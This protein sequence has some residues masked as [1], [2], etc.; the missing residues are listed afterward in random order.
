MRELTYTPISSSQDFETMVRNIDNN[1]KILSDSYIIRGL[2][3]ISLTP[4]IEKFVRKENNNYII[5]PNG[6][7]IVL[8][9]LGLDEDIDTSEEN[10]D[11]FISSL[12]SSNAKYVQEALE[13]YADEDSYNKIVWAGYK[14]KLDEWV[15]IILYTP[16]YFIYNYETEQIPAGGSFNSTIYFNIDTEFN[17]SYDTVS[18]ESFNE[19][20]EWVI[21]NNIPDIYYNEDGGEWRWRIN[22]V[23]TDF[24]L[25]GKPG[26]QGESG[27]IL[28]LYTTN[29]LEPSIITSAISPIGQHKSLFEIVNNGITLKGYAVENTNTDPIAV[30]KTLNITDTQKPLEESDLYTYLQDML[31]IIK[32]SVY[33]GTTFMINSQDIY[34][35]IFIITTPPDGEFGSTAERWYKYDM[36]CVGFM[37]SNQTPAL[38]LPLSIKSG[39]EDKITITQGIE[40][41]NISLKDN[42]IIDIDGKDII[43]QSSSSDI[44]ISN[45]SI[46]IEGKDISTDSVIVVK[47]NDP[48]TSST[49]TLDDDHIILS[50]SGDSNSDYV[51]ITNDDISIK[52]GSV[53]ITSVVDKLTSLSSGQVPIGG[54]ISSF[55]DL[56]DDNYIALDGSVSSLSRDAYSGF[57]TAMGITGDSWTVPDLSGRVL[58]GVQPTGTY[59]NNKSTVRSCGA[60]EDDSSTNENTYINIDEEELGKYGPIQQVN[61]CD[62]GNNR[63]NANDYWRLV[64]SQLPLHSHNTNHTHFFP[65]LDYYASTYELGQS[66]NFLSNNPILT[67]GVGAQKKFNASQVLAGFGLF[68]GSSDIASYASNANADAKYRNIF[69]E[70][71]TYNTT[72]RLTPALPSGRYKEKYW[73][74]GSYDNGHYTY[75]AVCMIAKPYTIYGALMSTNQVCGIDYYNRNIDGSGVKQYDGDGNEISERYTSAHTFVNVSDN[76]N[77]MG[78]IRKGSSAPESTQ[79]TNGVSDYGNNAIVPH[80]LTYEYQLA[81]AGVINLVPSHVKCKFYMRVK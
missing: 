32:D 17:Y 55:F 49:I 20:G 5:T 13:K 16:Y 74:V 28:S 10:L 15:D 57:F 1:F 51:N 63:A 67:T 36:I 60:R 61:A 4:H 46:D 72:K 53:E 40:G 64:P 6:K 9:I 70:I 22:G 43:I 59:S 7:N 3:G 8:K 50:K 56:D 73:Q 62:G 19:Y 38:N 66:G 27:K 42:S 37:Q 48:I 2:N 77:I 26:L 14:N 45:S 11:S 71:L 25:T 29:L 23:E 33:P 47:S 24:P 75:N 41:T 65:D 79:A 69:R 21:A 39:G 80:N 34:Q 18:N 78:A 35:Y 58:R 31:G 52:K 68:G 81:A 44:H 30:E 12:S 76:Y 54:I